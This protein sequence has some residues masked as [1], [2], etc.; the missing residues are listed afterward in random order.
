MSF[1]VTR[2]PFIQILNVGRNHWVTVAGV[3]SRVVYVYDSL[4]HNVLHDTKMQTAG[5]MFSN[6]SS[7]TFK[8]QNSLIQKGASDCGL[9][10]IAY[11]TDLAH[12]NDPATLR[13]NQ[14]KLRLHFLHCL[15]QK[16]LTPFPSEKTQPGKMKMEHVRIF[17]SCRLPDNKKENMAQC[18]KCFEWYHQSCGKIPKNIF[19]NAKAM[20]LCTQCSKH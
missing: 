7:I 8:M 18:Q 17:C 14:D 20:W 19:K 9:F 5:I 16:Q 2:D 10:A 3:P 4:N 13:Y 15:K 6:E 1:P 11:A 12:G